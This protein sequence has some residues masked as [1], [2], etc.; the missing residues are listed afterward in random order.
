MGTGPEARTSS[1]AGSRRS[2]AR[3]GSKAAVELAKCNR[4]LSG[5]GGVGAG[6][7]TKKQSRQGAMAG[8][9]SAGNETH[10]TGETNLLGAR[11]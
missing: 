3:S 10:E 9:K 11:E 1:S 4:L 7:S 8:P 5:H 6:T 2:P